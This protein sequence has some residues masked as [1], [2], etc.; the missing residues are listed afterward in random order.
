MV[1]R[2]A[3]EHSVLEAVEGDPA[4]LPRRLCEAV[5]ESVS[6]DAATLSLFTDTPHRQLLCATSDAALRLEKLQFGLGEGPCVTAARTGDKVIVNDLHQDLT[7]WPVFGP[8]AQDSL[9]DVG[10]IYAF[11]LRLDARRTLGAVDVL[12]HKA[13]DPDPDIIQRGVIAAR[14][15]SQALLATY[16]ATV[17]QGELPLWE[18][19]DILDSYWGP[20]HAAVGVLVIQLNITAEEALTRMRARAFGTDRS[21]PEIA[22]DILADPA[23]WSEDDWA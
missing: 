19:E 13:L 2:F 6:M 17:E 15:A 9:P 1:D 23:N 16:Q 10:A 20:T 5:R 14:T 21:L 3:V 22:D 12:C 7:G 8:C 18:P 11:P 4:R